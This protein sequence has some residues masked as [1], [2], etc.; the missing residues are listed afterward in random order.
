MGGNFFLHRYKGAQNHPQTSKNQKTHQ[1]WKK[2]YV[3][4]FKL[5]TGT[6]R[7]AS[8]S[9]ALFFILT[10]GLPRFASKNDVFSNFVP[11]LYRFRRLPGEPGELPQ[12][13]QKPEN[14]A[15]V[16]R[17]GNRDD[18][19]MPSKLPQTNSLKLPFNPF[20]NPP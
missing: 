19:S 10:E 1:I 16:T 4:F 12:V 15:R 9:D 6:P 5:Y 8:K 17:A 20:Q 13:G 7:F 14:G 18:V 11:E 2:N 3:F